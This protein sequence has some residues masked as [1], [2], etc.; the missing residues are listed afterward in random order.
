ML[1]E[2]L[3]TDLT[4]LARREDRLAI[5]VE[6]TVGADG[7]VTASDVYR[8]LVRNQAKLAYDSVAAWL[9]GTGKAPAAVAAQPAARCAAPHP[10]R[11]SRR[12]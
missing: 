7:A 3:S 5:V 8:A 6:M 12:P 2:R 11:A 4:S 1:P 9:D 10:G